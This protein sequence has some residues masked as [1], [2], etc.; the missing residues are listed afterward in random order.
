VRAYRL[1]ATLLDRFH[2]TFYVSPVGEIL[3]VE[4]PNKIVVVND[5]VSV[6]RRRP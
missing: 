6:L 3:R 4:L 2:A 5:R 1:K